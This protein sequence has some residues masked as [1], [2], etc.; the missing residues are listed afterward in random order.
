MLGAAEPEHGRKSVFSGLSAVFLICFI[1]SC[2]IQTIGVARPGMAADLDGMALYSWAFSIPGLAGTFVTLV[3]SKFSDMCGRRIMLMISL[4]IFL[5]GTV[6]SAMSPTFTFLIVANTVAR[7]GSGAITPLVFSVLGDMF[8]PRERS[9]WVGLP[10]IPSGMLALIGP[11]PGGLL[12][13]RAGAISLVR[14]AAGDS[15]SSGSADRRVFRKIPPVYLG[16]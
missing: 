15:M 12:I 8:P 6:L 5:P 16:Q 14:S 13:T 7:F 3:F 11:T 10:N 4:G 1:A 2:Y 9:R